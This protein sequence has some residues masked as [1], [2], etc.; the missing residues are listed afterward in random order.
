MVF[1]NI[2]QCLIKVLKTIIRKMIKI[3]KQMIN[4]EIN[5]EIHFSILLL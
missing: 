3:H 4:K 5:H 2:K 1:K